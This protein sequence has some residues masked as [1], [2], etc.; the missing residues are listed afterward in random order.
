M[1]TRQTGKASK[2]GCHLGTAS[3]APPL[4]YQ[5][6]KETIEPGLEALGSSC[7]WSVEA[8]SMTCALERF[9]GISILCTH[10]P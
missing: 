1:K 10:A 6:I 3:S 7:T 2:G 4:D 5:A 8:R 9:L